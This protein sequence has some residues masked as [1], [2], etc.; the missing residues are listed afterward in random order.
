M[1]LLRRVKGYLAS[2]SPLVPLT[3][4]VL[5][6]TCLV[7]SSSLPRSTIS[8]LDLEKSS[9]SGLRVCSPVSHQ[10]LSPVPLLCSLSCCVV[11][12][13]L[14][15][16]TSLY[17]LP[18]TGLWIGSEPS[19]TCWEIAIRSPSWNTYHKRNFGKTWKNYLKLKR[20]IMTFPKQ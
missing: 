7:L 5:P 1:T 2:S 6:F 12:S 15:L 17:C 10:P 13:T 20:T 18:S 9:L 14:P 19:T 3:W 16:K 4:M 8:I 11:P